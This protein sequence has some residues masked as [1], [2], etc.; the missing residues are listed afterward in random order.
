MPPEV[1]EQAAE[2]GRRGE[3][4][5]GTSR[6]GASR[7]RVIGGRSV[8]GRQ[9]AGD[10]LVGDEQ[11][12]EEDRRADDV[13][14]DLV[15]DRPPRGPAS[16]VRNQIGRA[17]AVQKIAGAQA[18]ESPP[19]RASSEASMVTAPSPVAAGSGVAGAGGDCS[20]PVTTMRSRALYFGLQA[21]SVT[22]LVPSCSRISTWVGFTMK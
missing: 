2:R 20:V 7:E 11:H 6:A 15:P 9:Q 19:A 17:S 10:V 1:V 16:Q 18:D 8:G 13:D 14:G 3:D 22:L 21:I 4:D 12:H 5:G